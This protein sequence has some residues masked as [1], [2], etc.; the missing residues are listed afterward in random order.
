MI[1]FRTAGVTDIGEISISHGESET[2][3]VTVVANYVA[4]EFSAWKS[5][6]GS[7]SRTRNCA[8]V[9]ISDDTD[10]FM[11]MMCSPQ[12]YGLGIKHVLNDTVHDVDEARRVL[13]KAEVT[14]E[15]SALVYNLAGSDYLPY[16]YGVDHEVFLMAFSWFR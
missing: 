11:I 16:T 10:V 4:Q 1:D 13:V 8:S 14:R 7:S 3:F 6:M 12:L 15:A 2:K 9:I 5:S